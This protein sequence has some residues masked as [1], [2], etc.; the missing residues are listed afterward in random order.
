MG[1]EVLLIFA[2]PVHPDEFLDL[3]EELGGVRRPDPWTNAR[4]S[5]EDRHVWVTVA[6]DGVPEF[7]PEDLVEYERKL[8]GPMLASVELSISGTEGG[9]AVAMEIIEAAAGRWRT[10]I[11]NDHGAVYTIEELRG[12]SPERL[13]FGGRRP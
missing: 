6:P 8:G 4:L 7:E 9:D 2:D 11:D 12:F 13:P 1:H 5:R 10:V 3:V